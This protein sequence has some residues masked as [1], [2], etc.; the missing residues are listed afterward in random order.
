MTREV[1]GVPWGD[2]AVLVERRKDVEHY[3]R[4]LAAAKIPYVELT[5]YDGVTTDRVKVGTIKRSKGLEFKFVLLPRLS[6]EAPPLWPGETPRVVRRALRAV[7][8]RAVRRDDASA[9]RVVAGVPQ[10]CDGGP[11]RLTTGWSPSLLV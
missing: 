2:L 9:G 8:S 5:R 6:H 10:R 7:A 11:T 4:V 1:L 3:Q